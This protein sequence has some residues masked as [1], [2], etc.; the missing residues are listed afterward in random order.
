[1]AHFCMRGKPHAILLHLVER[2]ATARAKLA[3]FCW[4]NAF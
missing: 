3:F 4:D 1:M 2:I